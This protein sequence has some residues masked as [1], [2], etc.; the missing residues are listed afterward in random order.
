MLAPQGNVELSD[1]YQRNFRDASFT[2]RVVRANQSELRKINKDFGESY[3]FEK[4]DVKIKEP[5]KIRMSA[6]VEDTNVLFILN[7]STRLFSFAGLKKRENLEDEPGKRQT[8]L[9]FGL[10]T[11]SLFEDLFV[12]KFVRK[13]RATN[14]Y[15]YDFNYNPRLKYRSWYRV[16]LDPDKKYI[17]KKEWYRRDRQLA[18]FFYSD[19][20]NFDGVW[21]PT[22]MTVKNVEDK[23]AGETTIDNLKVN[24]GLSDDLFKL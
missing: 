23:T 14:D 4:T 1:L 10:V 9:D 18:T 5:F 20:K 17:T 7:G 16:W 2:L 3:R 22:H 24:T 21:V 13:D 11:P 6:K 15:V 8:S 12:A 19:P